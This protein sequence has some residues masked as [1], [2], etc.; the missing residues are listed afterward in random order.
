MLL[1]RAVSTHGWVRAGDITHHSVSLYCIE[2]TPG[3]A[4][5]LK[6][7]IQIHGSRHFAE[8]K[9]LNCCQEAERLR[10]PA[11]PSKHR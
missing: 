1:R 10:R 4:A 11:L 7:I 8:T 5:D 9:V 2:V 6:N 3:S